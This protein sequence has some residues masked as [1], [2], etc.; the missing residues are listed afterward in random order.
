V[1]NKPKYITKKLCKPIV[2]VYSCHDDDYF[3]TLPLV[4]LNFHGVFCKALFDSGSSISLIQPHVINKIKETTKVNYLSHNLR[5]KTL[6]HHTIPYTSA[7]A[8]TFKIHNI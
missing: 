1:F 3:S 7:A 5:I 4:T 8:I 2:N 6:N